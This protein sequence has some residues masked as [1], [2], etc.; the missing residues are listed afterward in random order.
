MKR[1]SMN[2]AARFSPLE[3][4]QLLKNGGEPIAGKKAEAALALPLTSLIDAFSII[5]IYLLIGTQSG[6][7]EIDVPKRLNLP[8]A[9]SGI[10]VDKPQASIVRIEKG[11]YFVNNEAVSVQG[12]GAKLYQLKKSLGEN[13]AEIFIQADQEMNYA[14]LDPLLRA[15]SEAGIQKLKF[16]VMPNK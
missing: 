10:A 7:I 11:Q 15:G 3:Q 5:V 8:V 1:S 9:E 2:Q 14:D 4:A 16:A 6:G 13:E 12:L